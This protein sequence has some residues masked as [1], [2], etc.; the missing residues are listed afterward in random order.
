MYIQRAK[1]VYMT[2]P[3]PLYMEISYRNG[4]PYACVPGSCTHCK[5]VGRGEA[6]YRVVQ[7]SL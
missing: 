3:T 6:G 2:L 5:G 7:L 4:A 1:K